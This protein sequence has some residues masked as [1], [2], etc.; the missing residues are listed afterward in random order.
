MRVAEGNEPVDFKIAERSGAYEFIRRTLVQFRYTALDKADKGTVKAYL[1]KMTGLWRAQL[2]RLIA[3]PRDTGRVRDRRADGPARPFQRRY[4][5]ADIRLLADVDATLGE[6]C[7]PTTRAVLRRQFERFGDERFARLAR[8][9]N[10]HLYNLRKLRTYRRKRTVFTK[11][12]PRPVAIAQRRKPR[13]DGQPGFLRVD[14]VHQGDLDGVKGVYHINTVDEVTQYEHIGCVP[15]FSERFLVPVPE[16]LTNA[17]PFAIQGFHADNG[18]EY[19]NHRVAELLNKLHVGQFTKSRAGQCNDCPRRRQKRRRHPPVPRLRTHPPALRRPGQR[20][21]PQRA[22]PYLNHHRPCRF[23]TEHQDAKGRIR[24][25]YRD[26]DLATPYAKFKSLT[27]ATRFLKP[28]VTFSALDPGA[29]AQSDLDAAHTVNAAGNE[30]FRTL[31]RDCERA[32]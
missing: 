5:R 23:P 14:T 11:T 18:S 4:T 13:A 19:I 29:Y 1:A 7:G 28:A 16:A 31:G 17:Y 27:D 20:L 8:L 30:L 9:S 3:Q 22:S 2:T 12:R 10:G 21:H 25:R 26:Q 24:K 32:A 6:L 15:A